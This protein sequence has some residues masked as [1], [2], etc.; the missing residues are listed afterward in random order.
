M[1]LVLFS[2]PVLAAVLTPVPGNFVLDGEI[3][4]WKGIPPAKQLQY[5]GSTD[6]ADFLWLGRSRKGLVIAGLVRNNRWKFAANTS[7]L[8]ING[9]LEVW[10]SAVES[11]ELP[12]IKYNQEAC[13]V[14]DKP[15]EKNTCMQWIQ[16]QTEFREKLQKQATRIWRIAPQAAEEAYA[17]PA[18]DGFT[19]AQRKA[20]KFSRPAGLPLR[21]FRTSSDGALTFEILIPWELFP[22]ADRLSLERVRLAVDIKSGYEGDP[23]D[24]ETVRGHL[25]LF[26]VSPPIT[27]R[28]TTCEQPLLG[29]NM[30]GEDVPALYFLRPSLEIDQAFFFE[31]PEIPYDSPLP[32]KGDVSPIA[33]YQTFSAQ[34]LDKGEFLCEPF[35]SYRKG[36]VV[37]NFPFRLEPPGDEE[38]MTGLAPFPVK[39]Q[40]DGTR[41]ILYG[42]DLSRGPL[43]RKAF[44]VYSMR[45]YALTPSLMAYEALSIGAR[46]DAA[47]GYEIELAEDWR[48]VTEFRQDLSGKWTAEKFCLSG[49]TYRSCGKNPE[50]RPPRKRVLTSDQ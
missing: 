25:P 24:G 20:L 43:W 5:T 3:G 35:M 9:R 27:T 17:L 30:Q 11:F 1:S 2:F 12:E 10:L 37:R 18:Y 50:S 19:E 49:H 32:A 45:I 42:P 47:P 8:A 39:R 4:E 29:K 38:S 46:S 22:P 21:E 15:E 48:T 34:E 13:A 7:E 14:A 44:V 6:E 31:N 16:V 28:I 26:M 23:P 33:S 41:L 36:Q 40:A